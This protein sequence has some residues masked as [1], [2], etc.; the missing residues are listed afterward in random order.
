MLSAG[1][2]VLLLKSLIHLGCL[3]SIGWLYHA[4]WQDTLGPDPVERVI[5]FC[6]IASLNMLLLTLCVSPLAKHF[7]AG[8]LMQTR[9]LLGL[10]AAFFAL[11]HVVNYWVFELALSVDMFV[12]ELIKRPYIWVGMLALSIFSALS[13]TSINN[14]RRRM[15]RNWQRL[16]NLIYPLV[17]LVIWHFYWSVKA[18]VSE[19]LFYGLFALVL[20]LIRIPNRLNFSMVKRPNK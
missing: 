12:S 16:H 20:M 1:K 17:L 8:W 9:R 10:Y 2:K 14:I 3:G 13:V 6:G 15:G 19:P 7:K 18:N 4:A 5:H 11:L